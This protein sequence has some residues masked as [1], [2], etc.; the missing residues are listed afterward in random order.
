MIC[1]AIAL[2]SSQ[3]T[4]WCL[5]VNDAEIDSEAGYAYLRMQNPASIVKIT[6]YGGFQRRIELP[7]RTEPRIN[8]STNARLGNLT[9]SHKVSD[10]SDETR[11]GKECVRPSRKRWRQ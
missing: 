10:K 7:M 11:V 5:R 6:G 1:R 3:V 8:E 2:D 4:S 9:K